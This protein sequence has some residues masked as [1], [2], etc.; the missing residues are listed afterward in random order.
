MTD[1]RTAL[2]LAGASLIAVPA[3]LRARPAL[4]QA[5]EAPAQA[6]GFYRFRVGGFTVTTV[7]DGFFARPLEGFVRNAP[8]AEVQEAARAAFLPTDRTVI[9]FTITFVQRG[10]TLA[11]FDAG[12]G[13][14]PAGAT[15]GRMIANMAAAGIDPAR[16]THV[17]HSHFHGDHING[18]L[19]AEGGAAFPNAAVHVP[20]TEWAWWT[21]DGN[22]TRT[23][24]GQRPTFANVTRRFTPYRER[25]QQFQAGAEVLPGI[26]AVAAYGHTPGHT[27]FRIADGAEQMMFLA[28]LTN[29]PEI[30]MARPDWQIVFD[31][32]GDAASATRRRVLDMV[33][34]DRIRVT[35]YHYPFPANGFVARNGNGYRF[36]PADWS[37]AV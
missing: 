2:A 15:A 28:D 5:A 3:L 33:A 31:M 30:M 12:N 24:E 19:N 25:V 4:A 21:G 9:P 14:T 7:H 35:G 17:I 1:R 18:L 32:D 6:P 11:V 16:V 29:R 10:D 13:V 20:A 36:V 34:T 23:P 27:V 8:I 22:Q 37:S 26:T